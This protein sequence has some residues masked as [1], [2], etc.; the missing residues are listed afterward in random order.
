MTDGRLPGLDEALEYLVKRT[1]PDPSR[2]LLETLDEDD[3]AGASASAEFVPRRP[4]LD[5]VLDAIAILRLCRAVED[6]GAEGQPLS[7]ARGL[8]TTIIART[9]EDRKRLAKV[10]P[11]LSSV[12]SAVTILSEEAPD[13]NRNTGD[14]VKRVDRSERATALAPRRPS[15]PHPATVYDVRPHPALERDHF[16]CRPCR[17]PRRR[18]STGD[19]GHPNPTHTNGTISCNGT[20]HR[21]LKSREFL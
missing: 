1:R 8:L 9:W 19:L 3:L 17:S 16:A 20:K 10:I 2:T 15:R 12:Q 18:P 6:T 11:E 7:P 14:F 21:K 13:R 4:Y 5:E